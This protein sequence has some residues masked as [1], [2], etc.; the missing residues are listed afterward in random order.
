MLA[1]EFDPFFDDMFESSKDNL[2]QE[3]EIFF[4]SFQPKIELQEGIFNEYRK[5]HLKWNQDFKEFNEQ[6]QDSQE[7]IEKNLKCIISKEPILN[8]NFHIGNFITKFSKNKKDFQMPEWFIKYFFIEENS[9][10]QENLLIFVEKILKARF[11]PDFCT[12]REKIYTDV[13][14]QINKIMDIFVDENNIDSFYLLSVKDISKGIA[15]LKLYDQVILDFLW[16][17]IQKVVEYLNNVLADFRTFKENTK[18]S[19]NKIQEIKFENDESFLIQ[20]QTINMKKPDEIRVKRY[21]MSLMNGD[22]ASLQEG[23]PL[24]EKILFFFV[25]YFKERNTKIA[26]EKFN[27]IYILH[28]NFFQKLLPLGSQL[29]YNQIDFDGV[30]VFT[31]RHNGKNHT[32]FQSFDKILFLVRVDYGQFLIVEINNKNTKEIVVYDS[33]YQYS[34]HLHEKVIDIF[35]AYMIEELKNKGELSEDEGLLYERAYQGRSAWCPQITNEFDSGLFALMNFRALSEGLDISSKLYSVEQIMKARLDFFTLA[36]RIG[37]S[38]ENVLK[39]EI[40]V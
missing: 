21:D 3:S 26:N 7:K 34:G 4:K 29:D 38:E 24:K 2:F 19:L 30:K 23:L 1:E 33:N 32:I 20:F 36:L 8:N 25:E 5:K 27:L 22:L 12:S 28:Y 16:S 13:T 18:N 17:I 10:L 6:F 37:S 31:E 11:T 14:Q 9:K 40:L 15:E 39:F 35:R